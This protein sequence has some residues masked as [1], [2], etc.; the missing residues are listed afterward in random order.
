MRVTKFSFCIFLMLTGCASTEPFVVSSSHPASIEKRE[1]ALWNGPEALK[2]S[3]DLE[4]ESGENSMPVGSGH[5]H[6]H[7]GQ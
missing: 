3:P 7:G 1:E 6:M 2:Q 4:V 5:H